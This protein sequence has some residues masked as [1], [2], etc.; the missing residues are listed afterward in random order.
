MK[1]K[2]IN[3]YSKVELLDFITFINTLD[4]CYIYPIIDIT[5]EFN[6]YELEEIDKIFSI[7]KKERDSRF[8]YSLSATIKLKRN[9]RVFTNNCIQLIAR[10][11]YEELLFKGLNKEIRPELLPIIHSLDL[12]SH[13]NLE[14]YLNSSYI[15]TP[16]I[17]L[18]IPI[19]FIPHTKEYIVEEVNNLLP[20]YI[21]LE[22][23]NSSTST[24]RSQVLINKNNEITSNIT[25]EEQYLLTIYLQ[26]VKNR[27]DYSILVLSNT[28]SSIK[29]LLDNLKIKKPNLTL[30]Y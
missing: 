5:L 17:R 2:D 30:I 1:I 13:I 22:L 16:H 9:K 23:V 11:Y 12:S 7:Y 18:G 26:I 25:V 20:S 24:H 14:S 21:R 28:P 6:S 15:R 29:P 27:L 8:K 10:N 19:T 4:K 3:N